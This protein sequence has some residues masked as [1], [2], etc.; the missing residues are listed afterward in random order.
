VNALRFILAGLAL[1]VA[2]L[3]FNDP[4]PVYWVAVYTGAATVIG[5]RALGHHNEF[6]TAVAVGGVL[7]GMLMTVAGFGEYLLSGDYG[8]IFGEMLLSKP[9]VEET[10]ECLGLALTLVALLFAG[11]R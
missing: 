6:W 1:V 2:A 3:Q 9:Y 5:A 11:R 4:D 8:S 7:A 10:R